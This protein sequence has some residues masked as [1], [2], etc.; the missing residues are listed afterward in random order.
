MDNAGG[1]EIAD[2]GAAGGDNHRTMAVFLKVA[3]QIDRAALDAAGL[4]FRQYLKNIH[5][6]I[7]SAASRKMS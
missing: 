5:W 7:F 4:K 1:D 2:Q 3:R 6:I